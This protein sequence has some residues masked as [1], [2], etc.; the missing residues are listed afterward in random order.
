MT[1]ATWLITI[2]LKAARGRLPSE[3]RGATKS[4]Q[5]TCE[6]GQDSP[7]AQ[8]SSWREI[9]IEALERRE[10]RE[11]LQS[12]IHELCLACREVLLLRDMEGLS[13][14]ETAAV[15]AIDAGTVKVRLNRARQT[16]LKKLASQLG[17]S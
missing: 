6:R 3:R 1:L 7:P 10:T 15:L 5:R 4:I 17:G 8:L 11:I 9:P 16:I 12:A 13:V 2:T 14:D